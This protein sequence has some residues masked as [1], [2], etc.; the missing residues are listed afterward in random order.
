MKVLELPQAHGF[1][2]AV[3]HVSSVCKGEIPAFQ[4][5]STTYKYPLQRLFEL[6]A[7]IEEGTVAAVG[8]SIPITN[9]SDRLQGGMEVIQ[10]PNHS[11]RGMVGV[12]VHENYTNE[13]EAQFAYLSPNFE[14]GRGDGYNLGSFS[15]RN[16]YTPM[17]HNMDGK[18]DEV[19]GGRVFP[20]SL[21][22]F[23]Q[24]GVEM[25]DTTITR[26][27]L[28]NIEQHPAHP[29][30]YER[31]STSEEVFNNV[32]KEDLDLLG[33]WFKGHKIFHANGFGDILNLGSEWNDDPLGSDVSDYFC[34]KQ[35]IRSALK[36][37]KLGRDDGKSLLL[38]DIDFALQDLAM[39]R[40]GEI[41]GWELE[42]SATQ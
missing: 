14:P 4:F 37:R 26:S 35:P 22:V 16:H 28:H 42:E 11:D 34:I 39:A 20:L 18:V 3:D 12:S 31:Y 23:S 10:T 13:G 9:Q 25:P 21:T 6:F 41:M 15:R 33:N 32:T 24:G 7:A 5:Y 36:N 1:D 27:A 40:F 30:K 2:A 17:Q 38:P 8:R 29:R 19:Y